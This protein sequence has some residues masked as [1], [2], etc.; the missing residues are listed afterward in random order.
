MSYIRT[1]WLLQFTF[2]AFLACDIAW[3]A[4]RWLEE[5]L[6]ILQQQR[7]AKEASGT[8]YEDQPHFLFIHFLLF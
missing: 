8:E 2:R 1:A 7:H 3:F 5:P 4:C 6:I